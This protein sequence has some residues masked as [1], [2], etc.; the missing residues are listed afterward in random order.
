MIF[1]S[2]QSALTSFDGSISLDTTVQKPDKYRFFDQKNFGNMIS[3]GAGLSYVAASFGLK[4]K[5]IDHSSFN[6]LL[7]YRDGILEVEAGATLG[8]VYNYLRGQNRYLPVQPGHPDITVGGCVAADVHGKNQF[9]DGTFVSLVERIKLF[10]PKHGIIE[11]SRTQNPKLFDLT[12]GGFGLTG[13]IL[14]VDL[15]TRSIP[16]PFVEITT[17]PVP[18]VEDLEKILKDIVNKYDLVYSW[19]DFTKKGRGFGRGFIKAA[20]FSTAGQ[21]HFFSAEQDHRHLK[22]T[23]FAE[24]RG[25]WRWAFFSPWR[26][27]WFNSAYYHFNL[28]MPASQKMEL[29]DFLFPVHN[30]E[31]YFKFFGK[32]GFHECQFIIP[33]GKFA[34]WA[35]R[36]KCFLSHDST[37]VT[38]A[39]G[40]LFA[41]DPRLL[42]FTGNGVCMA[43]DFPRSAGSLRF[44]EF[45]YN[46]AMEIG[47][48]PNI[49]KDSDLSAKVVAATYPE[50]ERFKTELKLFDSE[51][52][53]RSELSERLG[54]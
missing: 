51:R 32:K 36:V 45:L 17:I 4:S 14:S 33:T 48:T 18:A 3:R 49:I 9:R 35:E 41:G 42:R 37:P 21:T 5:T 7:S 8:R 53:F 25:N 31:A 16:S 54:L 24:R 44:V 27:V 28:I 6:R 46:L 15:R 30:K 26:T 34:E 13:I 52:I 12:C 38:L 29:Y 20:K 43:L 10:H 19:H 40:K 11:L 22:R 1:P 23:L 47:A 2:A 50:Y 39:S